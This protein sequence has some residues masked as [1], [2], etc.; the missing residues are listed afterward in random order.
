MAD[1]LPLLLAAV[2]WTGA[3][4][5]TPLTICRFVH[6]NIFFYLKIGIFWLF[7][8]LSTALISS[9]CWQ[10]ATDFG[11]L[12]QLHCLSSFHQAGDQLSNVLLQWDSP[13]SYQPSLK[14]TQ[15]ISNPFLVDRAAV[16][17]LSNVTQE[18]R[19]VNQRFHHLV[20]QGDLRDRLHPPCGQ[21][22]SSESNV[23]P[24]PLCLVISIHLSYSRW[25]AWH[26]VRGENLDRIPL[27]PWWGL[28]LHR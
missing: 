5:W 3:S 18:T 4:F 1:V 15:R 8:F 22:Y 9:Y 24:L 6:L 16:L 26:S 23:V 20:R 14:S 10:P 27:M 19:R 17:Y 7:P 12:I 11:F 28:V 21:I 2:S 13:L 25:N